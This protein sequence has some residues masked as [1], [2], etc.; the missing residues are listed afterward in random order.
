VVHIWSTSR[1][2]RHRQPPHE[3]GPDGP[4]TPVGFRVQMPVTV[5]GEAH[6]IVWHADDSEQMGQLL[7]AWSTRF[8]DPHLPRTLGHQ[9]RAAGFQ[10]ERPEVLVRLNPEYDAKTCSVANGEIM[11]DYAVTQGSITRDQADAWTQDL[12]QHGRYFLA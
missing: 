5:Q 11:A 10:V 12:R 7:N 2:T 4:A 9:L 1:P 6:S 8:A 3:S